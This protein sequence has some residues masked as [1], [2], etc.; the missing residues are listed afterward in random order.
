M[1]SLA[2]GRIR[3]K[4]FPSRSVPSISRESISDYRTLA[5]EVQGRERLPAGI[6]VRRCKFANLRSEWIC[7]TH[8]DSEGTILFLH[9]GGFIVGSCATYRNFASRLAISTRSRVLMPEYRL[10]PEFPFPAAVKDAKTVY[11][12]LVRRG[13]APQKLVTIGDSAGGGLCAALL[14][15]LRDSGCQM[16]V[17]AVLISP[18]TDLTF[19]G[20]T[21]RTRAS[22]DPIDRLPALRRMAELYLGGSDPANPLAS[23]IF[24]D[25]DGLPKVLIQVGDHEVLLDD[26]LQFFAR[27]KERGVQAQIEVWPEMWHCWHMSAPA[28]PEANRAIRRI[29][30]FVRDAMS[31]RDAAQGTFARQVRADRIHNVG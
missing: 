26:S 12:E 10:A 27:A 17:A 15:A 19:S 25:L 7:S 4:L 20:E 29:G 1:V 8:V 30:A 2:A 24:G 28:L 5:V 13:T 22:A 9:G 11:D 31:E 16:P 14:L 18:W 3:T 21:Y 23:P 6:S